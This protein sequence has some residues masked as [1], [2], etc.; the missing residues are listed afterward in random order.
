MAK[1]TSEEADGHDGT[2]PGP[3]V[4]A[5]AR[6]G[7][8]PMAKAPP[9]AP[10]A[11]TTER[12][13]PASA[14][15]ASP[16]HRRPSLRTLFMAAGILAVVAGS[17]VFWLR[18]GRYAST[19]DALVQAAKLLVTT[20]VTGIVSSVNVH[21]NQGVKAGDQL[22]QLDLMAFQIALNNATANLHEVALTVESMKADYKVMLA[23][24]DAQQSQVDLDQVTYDRFASL[25]HDLS[26]SRAEY[27]QARFT[28]QLDKNKL[29]SLRQQ[30]DVQLA[31]LNGNPDIA[32]AD[33]PLYQQAKA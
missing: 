19:D 27:D 16:R 33:H 21:E 1:L 29:V 20:D 5:T 24:V 3:A 15:A 17:T 23:N 22:F 2:G 8:R 18:G 14:G 13:T 32:A 9:I 30:A 28:L 25:V 4:A 12:L 31:R 11:P 6:S 26:V 7:P 10:D